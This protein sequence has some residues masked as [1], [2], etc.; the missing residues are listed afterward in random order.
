MSHELRTPLNAIIGFSQMLQGEALGPL[1]DARYRGYAA[2]I[3]DSGNHLLSL[4][5]DVLDFS[6]ADA[7]RLKLDEEVLDVRDVL[8]ECLRLVSPEAQI[9]DIEVV[10]DMPESA[11]ELL[12]D[13]R[14]V[15]QIALN[16]LSNAL[17]FTPAGG[18]LRVTLAC[19]AD[20]LEIVFADNG[21]G[22]SP[23]QIPIAL[24]PFGQVDG[25]LNRRHEGTGLGL[26]LCCRFA[27]AHGGSLTIES[28][29]GEGTSVTVRFPPERVRK[30][31][32]A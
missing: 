1:G 4:I 18:T 32:A 21:I 11:P 23:D 10:S 7:G 24:E 30:A 3:L 12:A 13:R 20:G 27:E 31:R 16:L 19:D 15:K 9:S 2:D 29:L 22:M 14:R 17:K 28:A 6:K 25:R 26:P 8:S 5:N